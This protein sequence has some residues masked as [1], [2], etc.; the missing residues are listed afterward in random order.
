MIKTIRGFSILSGWSTIRI[1]S[2]M[3]SQLKWRNY[4]KRGSCTLEKFRSLSILL[5]LNK[6]PTPISSKIV[7][8]S[9]VS[10]SEL[11]KA[12]T[13]LRRSD[14]SKILCKTKCLTIPLTWG[15]VPTRI[16]YSGSRLVRNHSSG[17]WSTIQET[18]AT[19]WKALGTIFYL[20]TW[21]GYQRS[22]YMGLAKGLRFWLTCDLR[23]GWST[24]PRFWNSR[25]LTKELSAS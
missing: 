17:C 2:K 11:G 19:R 21:L 8:V 15:A 10:K 16:S 12:M 22:V 18:S 9:K 24:T 23:I 7:Q 13:D 20:W 4:Y 1:I 6:K 5:I 3:T 14:T 25:C